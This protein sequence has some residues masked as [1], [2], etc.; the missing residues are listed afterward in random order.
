MEIGAK[1]VVCID[2]SN[3]VFHRWFAL[4][5]WLKISQT[6]LDS[7]ALVKKYDTLFEKSLV[8]IKKKHKA[9]WCNVLLAKDC[10]RDSIW[11]MEYFEK[12]KGNR[13]HDGKDDTFDPTIFY[14]T[15]DTLLPALQAR[16]GFRLIG[17]ANAEADDVI[18]VIH[19]II[20]SDSR[21]KNDKVVIISND[22]D[23]LQL[24]DDNTLIMSN[25]KKDISLKFD[26][27]TLKHY[28][29][30]KIIKGDKSDNIPPIEKK[31][32]DK[33]A[34]K[35]AMNLDLLAKKLATCVHVE[36]QYSLNKTLI[37]FNEIPEHIVANIEKTYKDSV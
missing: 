13:T 28:L 19:R 4:R 1:K 27:D 7:V 20:R 14:H 26:T 32:G 22:T 17:S 31:I 25:T 18:A 16:Y 8:D 5:S 10:P 33:T 9:E 37:D 34:L 30:W 24:H 36:H 11:R 15:Y 3:Y 29:N 12:Y 6:E 23:Y 21:T 35:L 2:L